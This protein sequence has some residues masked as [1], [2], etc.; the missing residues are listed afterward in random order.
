MIVR[1]SKGGD[2]ALV[3][4]IIGRQVIS[5]RKLW[6]FCVRGTLTYNAIKDMCTQDGH[7]PLLRG[8][9]LFPLLK[10]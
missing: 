10:K 3:D 8:W 6:R 5:G 2:R 9:M 4:F 1:C 7:Y